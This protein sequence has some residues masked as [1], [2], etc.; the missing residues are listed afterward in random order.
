MRGLTKNL[1][2]RAAM[3]IAVAYAF[4]V[5]APAI[6]VAAVASPAAFHCVGDLNGKAT[7]A[8]QSTAAHVHDDGTA[9]HHGQ[10]G[11]QQGNQES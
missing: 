10:S 8:A 1:R 3:V 2:R 9:H 4:C 7:P 5:L 6:A 11:Q